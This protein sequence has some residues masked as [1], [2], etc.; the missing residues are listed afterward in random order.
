MKSEP[1]KF[2]RLTINIRPLELPPRRHKVTLWKASGNPNELARAKPA[3][4]NVPALRRAAVLVRR[5]SC[6]ESDHKNT[7]TGGRSCGSIE[8]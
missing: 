3:P 5:R 8:L 4:S 1:P 2:P 6:T 7:K